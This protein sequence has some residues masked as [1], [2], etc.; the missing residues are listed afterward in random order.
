M[1]VFNTLKT[2]DKNKAFAAEINSKGYNFKL[3]L[4]EN[5]ETGGWRDNHK[6]TSMKHPG[7]NRDDI[8]SRT[9]E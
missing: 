3:Q 2:A 8:M 7:V 5:L 4:S 9:S 6:P 1:L